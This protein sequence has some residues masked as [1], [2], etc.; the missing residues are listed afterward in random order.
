MCLSTQL[1]PRFGLLD[2]SDTRWETF[3]KA[4]ETL[5]A[6]ASADAS[7]K[8][9]F[10]ARHGQG[11]RAYPRISWAERSVLTAYDSPDNVA[12]GKFGTEAWD[13]YVCLIL[14]TIA[15]LADRHRPYSHWSKLNGDDELAWGPDPL[16]TPIGVAQAVAA[17]QAWK[18]EA[19]HGIPEPEIHYLSPLK[20]ALDT[21]KATFLDV[22]GSPISKTR[23][24][25]LEVR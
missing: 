3:K 18:T 1:P 16:L 25:I 23:G 21:W 20:R 6:G 13:R 9:F 14:V 24:I 7:F 19:S 5:N 10:L 22:E 11:Y 8:V 15:N 17:Q 12:E 2:E 4:I